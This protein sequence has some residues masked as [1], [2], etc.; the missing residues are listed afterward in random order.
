[1]SWEDFIGESRFNYLWDY[2]LILHNDSEEMVSFISLYLQCR[3]EIAI[4][5]KE[6]MN[7]R[8]EEPNSHSRAQT[9]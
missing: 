2:Y 4:A 9:S 8:F 5:L 7:A 6:Y 3:R 1:M